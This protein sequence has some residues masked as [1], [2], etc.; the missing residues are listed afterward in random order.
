MKLQPCRARDQTRELSEIIGTSGVVW[1]GFGAP[2]AQEA[3]V[4]LAKIWFDLFDC[5]VAFI[6]RQMIDKS[7]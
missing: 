2:V 4:R 7:T 1:E 3:F 5:P 6:I